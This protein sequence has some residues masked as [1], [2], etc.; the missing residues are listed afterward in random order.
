[1]GE[2]TWRAT[3]YD[4]PY[5]VLNDYNLRS[6]PVEAL[7]SIGYHFVDNKVPHIVI[8][9]GLAQQ[10]GIPWTMT[11]SHELLESLVDPKD[12]TI[13]KIG[14]DI[15]EPEICDPV[16]YQAYPIDGVWVSNF[17]T[18]EWFD[19]PPRTPQAASEKRYDF[20]GNLFT[21]RE[22]S[23]GGMRTL[24]RKERDGTERD[25][26]ETLTVLGDRVLTSD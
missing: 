6:M 4:Y 15:Y 11:F 20:A 19:K 13:F 12:E 3:I 5:Q 14:N 18:P 1:M 26:S 9:A 8:F 2:G 10:G 21:E 17:V 16:Q 23:L 22:R 7:N 25:R 24:R